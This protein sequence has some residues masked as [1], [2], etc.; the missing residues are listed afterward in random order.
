[1]GRPSSLEV[2]ESFDNGTERVMV[3]VSRS[4]EIEGIGSKSA[5]ETLEYVRIQDSCEVSKAFQAMLS[6]AGKRAQKANLDK[7]ANEKKETD[8][9]KVIQYFNDGLSTELKSEVSGKIMASASKA[10]RGLK[11]VLAG[12]KAMNPKMGQKEIAAL[13]LSMG[14]IREKLAAEGVTLSDEV[15]EVETASSAVAVTA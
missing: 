9:S 2:L 1:M 5:S 6:L 10:L 13:V 3:E 4:L 7:D 15:E 11:K 14:G 12:M 8:L